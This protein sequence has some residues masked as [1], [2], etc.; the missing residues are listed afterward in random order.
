M[1]P[2][3][4]LDLS[5]D[6]IGLFHRAKGGWRRLGE[7]S[8]D[9]DDFTEKLGHLRQT[10]AELAGGQFAT[11]LIIP[12]SQI[13]FR[14]VEAPG[15]TPGAR[16]VAIRAALDGTTPY[17]LD[18]L[19]FDWSDAGENMT[20]V[21]V[22]A[23][24][25]LREAEEF[26]AE[27]KFN[28]VAFVAKPEDGDF[29]GEPWFGT[30]RRAK[31]ILTNGETVERDDASVAE[32]ASASAAKPAQSADQPE[33]EATLR[34]LLDE[35]S[36]SAGIPDSA[37]ELSK[38]FETSRASNSEEPAEPSEPTK[39]EKLSKSEETAELPEFAEAEQSSEIA[40]AERP[41]ETAKAAMPSNGPEPAEVSD[42]PAPKD[43]AQTDFAFS[44]SRS[45]SVPQLQ[46]T[47]PLRLE[48]VVARIAIH[49]DRNGHEPAED[50][51]R[52]GNANGNAEVTH[53]S[54]IAPQIAGDERDTKPAKAPALKKSPPPQ[55]ALTAP[56]VPKPLLPRKEPPEWA[57]TEELT[58]FGARK[59][60]VA[61]GKPRYLGLVLTVA[62][63]LALAA[64]ALISNLI[65]GEDSA[66]SR[67]LRPAEPVVVATAPAAVIE[68]PDMAAPAPDPEP[69][70]AAAPAGPV[71]P[72]E[73]AAFH[74]RTGIWPLDPTVPT[75]AGT[76]LIDDL[77]VAS[78]DPVIV[79]H[80]AVAL[81][82]SQAALSDNALDA[83]QSPTPLGTR[84]DLDDNGLVRAVPEGALTPD[85]ILVIAG[86]PATVPQPRPGQAANQAEPAAA[87]LAGFRPK[88]R[89]GG[90]IEANEKSRLGGRTLVQLAA[91]RPAARPA[92]AQD[93][94]TVTRTPP[95]EFAVLV[96]PSP[97]ARPSDFRQIVEKAVA[98]AQASAEAQV[99]A[100]APAEEAAV[101]TQ[102]AIAA[103]RLPPAASPS[104]V[105][106]QATVKNAIDLGKINLIGVYGSSSNRRALIRLSSGKYVKVKVGDRIDGGQVAAIGSSELLYVKNGRRMTLAM[107]KG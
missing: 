12:N 83:I 26:A 42:S 10:A 103:P 14:D 61:G 76:D 33:P 62:L 80:D 105:A 29:D 106:R 13:L 67:F 21:A 104:N 57:R 71:T 52:L 7:V 56:A 102:A 86:S 97:A 82:S 16:R 32:L 37:A 31:G 75:G 88:S 53:L 58:V 60:A 64:A 81:P 24:E 54:V 73:A 70:Q 22:V 84:F 27:H 28:P 98:E 45:T 15:D 9:D 74:A 50:L 23:A 5:F 69:E 77:Y 2:N 93:N 51:P 18:D 35:G 89:P 95:S 63:I 78:I 8:L 55:K 66:L 92:S 19:V 91:I 68:Q 47:A 101:V 34:E 30:T 85:G 3:F 38:I 40:K 79:G 4:A 99:S 65:L 41:P 107:P 36:D 48:K 1:K 100:A 72:D 94:D 39:T 87:T 6:R 46:E 90:L 49:A 43:Q 11:K 44:T 59:S 96:S 20:K 17:T 25:T